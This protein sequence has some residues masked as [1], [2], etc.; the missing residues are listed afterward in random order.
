MREELHADYLDRYEG[1][2][3]QMHQVGQFDDSCAVST[4]YLGKS[5]GTRKG[6]L[7]AHEQFSITD[8]STTVGTLLD[9]TDCK[10][11]LDSCITKSFISKQ[12]FL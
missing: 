11:L 7:K 2:Q 4:T 8:W 12:Y 10:I 5:D 3:M 9:G 1:G 6:V